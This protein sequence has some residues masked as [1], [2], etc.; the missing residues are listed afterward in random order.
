MPGQNQQGGQ[1]NQQ[2]G[3]GFPGGGTTGGNGTGGGLPGQNQQN[4]NGSTQ[5][6]GQGNG[7]PGATT[8]E[9]GGMG[10]GGGAY[11]AALGA[12]SPETFY[13]GLTLTTIAMLVVGGIV[14]L[15]GAVIGSL[16]IS[17]VQELMR[18]IEEGTTIVFFHVNGPAGIVQLSTAVPLLAIMILSPQGLTGGRELS[19]S[20][21]RA[22]LASFARRRGEPAVAQVP[23]R[24]DG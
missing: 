23:G 4:G 13:L 16:L 15:S 12:F 10:A 24:G 11:A 8:G 5:G 19:L 3:N 6:Q 21:A 2:N 9:G 17:A 20:G 7:F 22:L 18:R 1:Q 14:S